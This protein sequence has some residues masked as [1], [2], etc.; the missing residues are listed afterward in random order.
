[1]SLWLAMFWGAHLHGA[2][3][4]HGQIQITLGE[5]SY[6]YRWCVGFGLLGAILRRRGCESYPAIRLWNRPMTDVARF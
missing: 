6:L 1:M 3:R 4:R 2:P 5:Q